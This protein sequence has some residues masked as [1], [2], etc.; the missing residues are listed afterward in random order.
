M[1]TIATDVCTHASVPSMLELGNSRY[2]NDS[3]SSTRSLFVITIMGIEMRVLLRTCVV[4]A[5][6]GKHSSTSHRMQ[7]FAFA[8][9]RRICLV[10][11]LFC[12]GVVGWWD[13]RPAPSLM[14]CIK[15]SPLIAPAA[16]C[17]SS[18]HCKA[19]KVG[20]RSF[21]LLGVELEESGAGSNNAMMVNKLYG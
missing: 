14:R 6:I 16:I 13:L 10:E 11:S 12:A 5:E 21:D 18:Y 1:S 15:Y 8:S 4:L 17:H 3:T 9:L 7:Y 20:T 2:R 19:L